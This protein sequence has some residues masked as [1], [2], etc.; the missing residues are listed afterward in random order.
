MKMKTKNHWSSVRIFSMQQKKRFVYD[1]KSNERNSNG[2]VQK[3]ACR[4]TEKKIV[5]RRS[6]AVKDMNEKIFEIFDIVI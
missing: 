4:Q 3:N 2:L 5:N 1:K 6:Y